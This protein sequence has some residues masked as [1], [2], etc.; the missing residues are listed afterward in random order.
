MGKGAVQYGALPWRRTDGGL[1]ILL[2]TT[3]RTR[4][5]MI[6]KGW[7]IGGLAPNEAAAQEAWEEAG[8]HGEAG[9]QAVGA[10]EYDKVGKVGK[11][12]ELRR[13]R[14][15]VFAL[16]VHEEAADWPEAAE[17][18]RRWFGQAEAAAV[19]REAELAALLKDFRP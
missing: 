16:A 9:E 19:V 3:R 2:I 11:D 5:W 15:D 6:P 14:V 17:R 12:G 8:V 10:F 13:L 7:P 4:R 18:E 1:E